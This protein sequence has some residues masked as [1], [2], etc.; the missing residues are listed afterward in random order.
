MGVASFKKFMASK[1]RKYNTNFRIS[2]S[3]LCR[4]NSAFLSA[5]RSYYICRNFVAWC[6]LESRLKAKA[7]LRKPANRTGRLPHPPLIGPSR[8]PRRLPTPP[9]RRQRRRRRRRQV[10][11]AAQAG[12]GPAGREPAARSGRRRRR[13]SRAGRRRRRWPGLGREGGT[14]GTVPRVQRLLG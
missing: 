8:I 9:S 5:D 2:A 6:P 11:S 13:R 4:C 7:A 10:P 3:T 14:L 1:I 12:P